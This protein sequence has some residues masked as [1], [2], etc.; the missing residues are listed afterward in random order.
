MHVDGTWQPPQGQDLRELAEQAARMQAAFAKAQAEAGVQTITT[1]PG[2]PSGIRITGKDGETIIIDPQTIREALSLVPP[3]PPPPPFQAP[4]P[5]D[6]IVAIVIIAILASTA[7]L[8]PIARAFGRRI[9]R[10]ATVPTQAP[11]M[12][13]RLERIEQAVDAIAIE[14]ERISEGQRFT[15]KILGDRAAE[16]LLVRQGASDGR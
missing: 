11:E 4:G 1:A 5:P 12:A 6:S 15:T 9:D 10:K 2:A 16:P 3:P 8:F 14:V 13:G 7:V